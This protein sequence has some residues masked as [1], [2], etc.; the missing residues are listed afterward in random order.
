M[1]YKES[2]K[3]DSF[4]DAIKEKMKPKLDHV[5][6][7]DITIHLSENS[8]PVKRGTLMQNLPNLSANKEENPI[9]VKVSNGKLFQ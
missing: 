6:V 4:I 5:A 8:D 9:I 1:P 2:D 3:V 7:T